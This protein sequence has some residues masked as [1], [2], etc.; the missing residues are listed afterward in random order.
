MNALESQL[1]YPFADTLPP[2]G[3]ALEVAPG[4]LWLRMPL[5]FA[6]DHINLWL[7]DDAID[8]RRGWSLIDSGAGTDATRAAWEQLFSSSRRAPGRRRR[9]S[10]AGSAS[11]TSPWCP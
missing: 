8:G 3:E 1:S 2:L 7:V 10:R 4:L 5:P 11:P 6:L 9:E